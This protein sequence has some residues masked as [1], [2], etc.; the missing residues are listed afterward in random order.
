MP[1]S[2]SDVFT[3]SRISTQTAT[4]SVSGIRENI[5]KSRDTST[6]DTAGAGGE[7]GGGGGVDVVS[8]QCAIEIDFTPQQSRRASNQD[9]SSNTSSSSSSGATIKS[10]LEKRLSTEL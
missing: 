9:A 5:A 3:C 2:S 4:V 6:G 1:S 7:G 8:G 10:S